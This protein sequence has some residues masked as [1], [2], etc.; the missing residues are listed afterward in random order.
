MTSFNIGPLDRFGGKSAAIRRP[1]EIACFSYDNEH[2]YHPDDSSMRWYYPPRLGADLS[3]GFDTFRKL[4]DT[5]DDH[6]DSLLKTL[7]GWEKENGTRCEADVITWRGMMTKIMTTPFENFNGFIEE[8]HEYKMAQWKSQHSQHSR[9]GSPSQDLMSFWGYKFESLSLLPQPWDATSREYIEGRE[10]EIVNNYAQYCSVVKTGIGKVRL[11][12]G[13]EV[14]AV[15]DSKPDSKDD[16]ISWV[17]LKTSE[18]IQNDRDMMKFERKLL[19]FWVQSFL[20]GVPKI[21]VGFRSRSGI[22]QRLEELETKSIPGNVKRKGKGT[23]DGNLCINFTATFLEWLKQEIHG[24]G[25]WR[26]RRR[27]RSPFIEVYQMPDYDS[28]PDME[29]AEGHQTETASLRMLVSAN[30]KLDGDI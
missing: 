3:S 21:I 10:Q 22:L 29:A 14:D 8:N 7:I 16:P 25:V 20:L 5:A 13:G 4:D 30:S 17:E 9:H 1:K 18:E 12:I 11:V 23:W 26:I 15:W 19:K 6:L 27:E 28:H 2:E 24:E